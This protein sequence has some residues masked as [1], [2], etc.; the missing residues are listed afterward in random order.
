MAAPAE[1]PVAIVPVNGTV[2]PACHLN[3]C[4]RFGAQYA[5][6]GLTASNTTFVQ[7][8]YGYKVSIQLDLGVA[9]AVLTAVRV[10]ARTSCCLDQ[11]QNITVYVSTNPSFGTGVQCGPLITF[12]TL[13]EVATVRCPNI[14]A[15]YVTVGRESASVVTFLALQEITPL[16]NGERASHI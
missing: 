8:S 9:S 12:S 4:N 11:S 10:V 7:S 6:D 13:G 2:R 1:C 5:Y 15:R 3:N 14:T 16:V